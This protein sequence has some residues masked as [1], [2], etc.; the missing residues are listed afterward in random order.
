ML[1]VPAAHPRSVLPDLDDRDAAMPGDLQEC[2]AG[3]SQLGE[4]LR[5]GL[6]GEYYVDILV[7]DVVEE[8]FVG[9]HDIV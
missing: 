3:V 9:L 5:L 7:H 8:R 2:V 1:L 4:C 6:V